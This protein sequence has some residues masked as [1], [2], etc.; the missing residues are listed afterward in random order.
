MP[1]AAE[2]P[3]ENVLN[4]DHWLLNCGLYATDG[5]STIVKIQEAILNDYSVV[6]AI[7]TLMINMHVVIKERMRIEGHIVI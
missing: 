7:K 4:F 1:L 3:W 6:L 2:Y 5:L